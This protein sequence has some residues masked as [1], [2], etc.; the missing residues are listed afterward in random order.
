MTTYSSRNLPPVVPGPESFNLNDVYVLSGAIPSHDEVMRSVVVS[1][2][3][4]GSW[5]LSFTG[6][7]EAFDNQPQS[8]AK[9]R[10]ATPGAP[11]WAIAVIFLGLV[12]MAFGWLLNG[13][14]SSLIYTAIHGS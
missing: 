12:L 4:T 5:G 3:D 1:P 2:I 7:M 9:G 11:V 10:T 13:P 8:H 6:V 14:V